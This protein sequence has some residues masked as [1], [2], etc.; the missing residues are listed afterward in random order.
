[1]LGFMLSMA[2][3]FGTIAVV[4][5]AAWGY[6]QLIGVAMGLLRDEDGRYQ[7]ACSRHMNA[8]TAPIA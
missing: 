4:N 3:L 6:V 7:D 5:V 1:M 8:R 2:V